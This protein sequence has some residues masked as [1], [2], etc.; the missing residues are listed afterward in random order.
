M[1]VM[2]L[3]ASALAALRPATK[4][5]IMGRQNI[6]RVQPKSAFRFWRL[7]DAVVRKPSRFIFFST[8]TKEFVR[9]VGLTTMFK[10]K[11]HVF[12]FQNTRRRYLLPFCMVTIDHGACTGTRSMFSR[13]SLTIGPV[14]MPLNRSLAA[15]A[16][17]F[18]FFLGKLWTFRETARK[19][20]NILKCGR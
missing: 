14:F 11:P 15:I 13:K 16:V 9:Q 20:E 10:T 3:W 1:K 7:R 6:F 18:I 17:S 12:Q 19:R 4:T 5:F 8:E 2:G